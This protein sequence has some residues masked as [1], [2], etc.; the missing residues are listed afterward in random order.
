MSEKKDRELDK[1]DGIQKALLK[2]E[3]PRRITCE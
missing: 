3:R 2:R 1:I